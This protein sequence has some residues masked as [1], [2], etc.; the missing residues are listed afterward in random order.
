MHDSGVCIPYNRRVLR[1]PLSLSSLRREA[2]Y[3][4]AS[5]PSTGL[6]PSQEW[7]FFGCDLSDRSPPTT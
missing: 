4:P 6:D 5:L 2:P 3:L 1:D 7:R